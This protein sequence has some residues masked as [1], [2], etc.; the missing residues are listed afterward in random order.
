MKN[1]V[2]FP[3]LV[4]LLSG[5][6]L[7]AQ[8]A[9][10][11]DLIPSGLNQSLSEANPRG[12][13]TSENGIPGDGSGS[14]TLPKKVDLSMYVPPVRSQGS[15]G[16]CA[17]WST[18]YYAKTMQE[19]ME[20]RWDVTQEDHQFSPLFTYNQ[21]TGGVNKG[22]YIIDHMVMMEKQGV[23]PISIFP[24]LNNLKAFPD[25]K[26]KAAAVEYLSLSHKK[27]DE[28]NRSTGTW[29][30]DIN[31]VKT[32]LA[33]SLPVV[34]GFAT[35]PNFYRYRGGI[36]SKVSGTSK[37]GHAMCVVGYDDERHAFRIVNSWG[38]D[39]G[40]D[41]FMWM[42]YDLFE[43]LATYGSGVMYDKIDSS[44]RN[45]QPPVQ[46]EGTKG[47]YENKIELTWRSD[48]QADY[49][50]IYRVDNEESILK[51]I[52]TSESSSFTDPELPPGVSYVYAVKS[53]KMHSSGNLESGFSEIAEAWTGTEETPPGIPSSLRSA[54]LNEYPV[55]S[56]QGV[57]GAEG[58]NI[59]RWNPEKEDY[60]L[61]GKSLDSS[62]MDTGF[63]SLEEQIVFYTI[64][65]FNRHGEG[66]ASDGFSIVK[67][68]ITAWIPEK[69]RMKIAETFRMTFRYLRRNRPRSEANTIVPI[70]LIMNIP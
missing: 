61:I 44:P 25:E 10:G 70:I 33:E 23:P 40:E 32:A 49:Y 39:W 69:N 8:Q 12:L 63:P 21:I 51:K 27:L 24:H 7:L 14:K 65:A 67:K 48:P 16:S 53:V 30:V 9:Q 18:V 11:L 68:K 64:Q 56:W 55:L 62:Y 50:L 22:T 43:T 66:F 47:A 17:A 34:V 13:V 35:Y 20:R 29:R 6:N 31:A 59:Y 26:V 1:A 54:F 52:G 5:G 36:Y 4:L 58:Y 37:S 15:I 46:L 45:I 28:Y 57:E 3:I 2:L 42:D 60:L 41:G 19:N 38:D